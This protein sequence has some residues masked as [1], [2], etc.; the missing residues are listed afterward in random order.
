MPKWWNEQ[1][2][3]G[4]YTREAHTVGARTGEKGAYG[5]ERHARQRGR[6]HGPHTATGVRAARGG[7]T[8]QREARTPM[9]HAQQ[10]GGQG[11]RMPAPLMMAAASRH[12]GSMGAYTHAHH[13]GCEWGARTAP[14][15]GPIYVL[16]S[17]FEVAKPSPPGYLS[18]TCKV[19]CLGLWRLGDLALH[20]YGGGFCYFFF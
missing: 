9:G 15:R 13:W 16:P 20:T 3:C 19:L 12:V 8:R 14:R 17:S 5:K 6:A 10:Q 4:T 18:S 1:Q 7:R 2:V 11:V